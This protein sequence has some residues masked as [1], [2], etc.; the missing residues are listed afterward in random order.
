MSVTEDIISTQSELDDIPT[1]NPEVGLNL[2]TIASRILVSTSMSWQSCLPCPER[3]R[4]SGNGTGVEIRD[5]LSPSGSEKFH[6][7]WAH[8]P[9]QSSCPA[10]SQC[11][12]MISSDKWKW[13]TIN[14]PS[15]SNLSIP[16]R[17]VYSRVDIQLSESRSKPWICRQNIQK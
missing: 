4:L 17:C 9:I 7:D 13:L 2:E 8:V 5:S 6:V 1:I 3:A 10:Q 16:S 14:R 11:Q 12:F 15:G